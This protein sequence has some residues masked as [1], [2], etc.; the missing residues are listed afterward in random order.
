MAVLPDCR[1]KPGKN[2]GGGLAKDGGLVYNLH[3]VAYL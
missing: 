2:G 1:G 3:L